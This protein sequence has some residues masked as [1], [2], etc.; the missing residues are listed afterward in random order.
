VK[1]RWKIKERFGALSASTSGR[2]RLAQVDPTAVLNAQAVISCARTVYAVR[3]LEV[4]QLRE[5]DGVEGVA[6][7]GGEARGAV[8]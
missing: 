4:G 1:S 5:V 7:A 2:N 8:P 6:A 3:G